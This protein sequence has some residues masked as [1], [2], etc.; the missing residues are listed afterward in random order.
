MAYLFL[1]KSEYHKLSSLS[2]MGTVSMEGVD[3]KSTKLAVD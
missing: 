2:R 1:F 3:T